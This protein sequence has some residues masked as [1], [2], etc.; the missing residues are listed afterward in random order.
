MLRVHRGLLVR[1]Q[2]RLLAGELG[3]RRDGRHRAMRLRRVV[4]RVVLQLRA[5]VVRVQLRLL[6]AGRCRRVVRVGV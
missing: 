1:R 4:L 2:V 3:V 6:V 5:R